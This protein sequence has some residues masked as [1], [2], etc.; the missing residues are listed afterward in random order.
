MTSIADI[1]SPR[2]EPRLAT[3]LDFL[4]ARRDAARRRRAARRDRAV[5]AQL[6]D[7]ILSDIGRPRPAGAPTGQLPAYLR[8]AF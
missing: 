2:F 1:R 4:A 5:L 6:D 3:F 7:H 8:Y